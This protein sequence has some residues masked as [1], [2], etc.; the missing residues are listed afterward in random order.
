MLHPIRTARAALPFV[1]PTLALLGA[2][3]T[4]GPESESPKPWW[5]P[6]SWSAETPAQTPA[7]A[8]SGAASVP[9]AAPVDPDWWRAFADPQLTALEQRLAGANLDLRAAGLRLAE[10]RSS[11]GIAKSAALPS[12]NA[13][14]SY[15]REQLSREGDLALASEGATSANGAGETMAS[16]TNTGLF[17]PFDLYQYG[18]DASW[19][20]D[21]WGGVKRSIEAADARVSS[22]AEARRDL[23]VTASAELA[24]DYVDLRGAQREL[25]ITQ[26]NLDLAR[27]TLDLTHQ[28]ATAGVTT[29]LDVA[30]AAAQVAEVQAQLPPL[31]AR[32]ATLINAISQLF[33]QAPQAMRPELEAAKPIPPVPPEV[34]VGVPSDLVSRRPDL[35]RAE[36]DLR[37]ATAQVGVAT[38][39]FYPRLTLMGSGAIQGV[40]LGDLADW[41][42]A[43]TYAL[44]PS[45]SLPIFEGGKLKRTL[46]LRQTQQQEAALAWQSTYL[47]ALHEVDNA[48]TAYRTEQQRRAR[49]EEE[50]AQD[51]H[52][53]D[54]AQERYRDG[55]TDFLS[56][57]VVERSL[58][59]ADRALAESTTSVSTD[60]VEIYKALGGGWEGAYPATEKPS[61]G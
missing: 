25:E 35:R 39:D 46:E 52:A 61:E 59:D 55:V 16:S 3:C 9:V 54:L 50:A 58:L 18:F 32:E 23:L 43:N 49:L 30:N 48:L 11:L 40:D 36:A 31:E 21:L 29:D 41:A 37:V 10:A 5:N 53:F 60:L 44:G 24:R 26:H 57:L 1:V 20:V 14:A 17:R 47:A 2:A 56:V 6:A 4:V 33:G 19:E 42:H 27:Q 45:I 38:A 28:R 13:N 12:I 15:T 22:S 34:G 7:T 8:S 51:R